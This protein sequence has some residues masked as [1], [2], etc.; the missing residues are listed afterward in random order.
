MNKILIT[1]GTGLV[2]GRLAKRLSMDYEVYISSR[3]GLDNNKLRLYG[4]V[5]GVTHQSLLKQSEFPEVDIVIHMASLNERDVVEHPS[6]AI[7]V[8][9]DETR[10][11]VENS[12]AKKIPH[13]Y[14]F[15]TAHIYGS[16]L[17]GI[18]TEDT[19]PRPVHPYSITHRAAEDYVL[20]AAARNLINATVLRL[21][22]SFGAPV[23]SEVN[24][25]TLLVNDLCRQ[26]AEK[27]KMNLNS[28]GC[29][30]R[31]FICLTDVENI[32][33]EMLRRSQPLRNSI[34]NLGSG[35]SIRVIDMAMIIE[36]LCTSVLRE[37][38]PIELPPDVVES[39][40]PSFEY[41]IGRLMQEGFQVK[42]D[43]DQEVTRLLQYCAEHFSK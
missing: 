13:F 32:M 42:N 24:R 30:Y 3:K 1:G 17:T 28:N 14:Y 12:V 23:S 38:I 11:I 43:I 34:Y 18:I 4:N 37:K 36:R 9:I 21:S 7:R 25:W 29:Q 41:S 15:S 35:V 22:N 26:A 16:P 8:N 27:G 2:G 39:T 31:D 33:A 6:E 5:T 10:I 19:L 40:E 20:A